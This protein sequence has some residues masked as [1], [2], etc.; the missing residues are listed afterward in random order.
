MLGNET[1]IEQIKETIRKL[2]GKEIDV[3]KISRQIWDNVKT[4]EN[5]AIAFLATI[6]PEKSKRQIIEGIKTNEKSL[7]LHQMLMGMWVRNALRSGGFCYDLFVMERIW[8][9]WLGKAVTLPGNKII[10]TES[11]RKRIEKYEAWHDS[12]K[13]EREQKENVETGKKSEKNAIGILVLSAVLMLV[14][15]VVLQMLGK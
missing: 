6:I 15:S 9:D 2:N 12:E 14:T 4:D 1:S 5:E 7:S 13:R 10:V 11:I 3:D 8:D